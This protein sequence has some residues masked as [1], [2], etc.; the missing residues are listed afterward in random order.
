MPLQ[1]I[2]LPVL[3]S[4]LPVAALLVI[5]P[6]QA[7][8]AVAVLQQPRLALIKL[9]NAVEQQYPEVRALPLGHIQVEPVQ[10]IV[11][12]NVLARLPPQLSPCVFKQH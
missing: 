5:P 2:Q 1:F 9:G 11:P 10:G 8:P 6:P 3:Q 7:V 12:V 4:I